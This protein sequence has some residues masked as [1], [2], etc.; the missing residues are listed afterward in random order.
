MTPHPFRR[1]RNKQ[2]LSQEQLAEKLG[3]SRQMVG[4][5]EAGDRRVTAENAIEWERVTGIQRA[6]LCPEI[7]GRAAA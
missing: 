5:I 2:N 3:V 4:L 6:L 7:F 1:Y